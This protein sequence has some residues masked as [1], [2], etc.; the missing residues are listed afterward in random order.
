MKTVCIKDGCS[1]CNACINVCSKDAIF[2]KDSISAYNAI[3]DEDKC[4]KCNACKNVCPNNVG[5][6]LREPLYY[7]RGWTNEN[8]RKQGSSGG[9][10]TAI[11]HAFLETGGAICSCLLEKGEFKYKIVSSID[12]LVGFSG[13]K[14]VKSNPG[15][16]YKQI[17][18]KLM[19]NT[20]VLFI[21]LPCHVAGVKSIAQNNSLLYT[22]D[23]ICHGTPSPQLLDRYL[24]DKK[25][26]IK[27]VDNIKF[28]EKNRF[29]LNVDGNDIVPKSVVDS[30]TNAFLAGLDYTENCYS[31]Q[32]ATNKRI[33]DITLGDCWGSSDVEMKKGISLVLCQ[34]PKGEELL[35]LSTL[36]LEETD[37]EKALKHN[38]QLVHPS[39]RHLKRDI[40]I[41]AILEG[42]SFNQAYFRA[43]SGD[44][45]KQCIKYFLCKLRIL[46]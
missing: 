16:V 36:F 42:K 18:T 3:I 9:V 7:M 17:K 2:I 35:K 46:K 4:V 44:G 10:A 45:L 24:K 30:Y 23:L 38:H 27:R 31:C 5:A 8:I 28:R 6:N 33:S 22:V 37:V 41:K 15:T 14:Y 13:S 40:F 19:N 12:E 32:F 43:N 20:K 34:T 39:Y 29:F 25:I 26:D 1:G 21:G 11:M